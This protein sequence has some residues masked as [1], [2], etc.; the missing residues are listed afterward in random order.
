MASCCKRAYNGLLW[1]RVRG[2]TWSK[3]C[4]GI[5]WSAGAKDHFRIDLVV[6]DAMGGSEIAYWE[7]QE[8]L[9]E[10]SA[11]LQKPFEMLM[12]RQLCFPVTLKL[13]KLTTRVCLCFSW[14]EQFLCCPSNKKWLIQP[15]KVITLP[16]PPW[17]YLN[18]FLSH[19]VLWKQNSGIKF[20]WIVCCEIWSLLGFENE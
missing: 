4:S 14:F 3:L 8:I 15:A 17:L 1:A 19:W 2:L 12:G 20:L 5:C 10:S 6:A 18:F 9:P 16:R 13:M 11:V 7:A